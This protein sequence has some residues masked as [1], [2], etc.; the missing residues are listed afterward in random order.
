MSEPKTTC[1]MCGAAILQMTADSND[2]ACRR[3]KPRKG[4]ARE[5]E[6]VE[7]V[8]DTFSF[9]IRL[10]F[11]IIF[12]VIFATSGYSLGAVVWS[13]LG[14]MLALPAFPLGFLF[15][16]FIREIRLLIQLFLQ[17]FFS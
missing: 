14:I 13:G 7:D 8:L 11:A 12:G 3:C 16:W 15:G 17:G 6:I 2:G 5:G 10:A 1:A 9:G 4:K